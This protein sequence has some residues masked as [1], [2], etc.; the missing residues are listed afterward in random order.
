MDKGRNINKL[1]ACLV[2]LLMGAS[3]CALP[4]QAY[5]VVNLDS[6]SGA[7]LHEGGTGWAVPFGAGDAVVDALL[8]VIWSEDADLG[9][10]LPGGA[11]A[12]DG[13][14]TDI[15][16]YSALTTSFGQVDEEPLDQGLQLDNT[17]GRSDTDFYNGYVYLRVF[18]TDSPV[19]GSG[20][21]SGSQ[22]GTGA[23]WGGLTQNPAFSSD[24]EQLD[25]A[26]SGDAQADPN[27]PGVNHIPMNMTIVPEPG[28][29]ALFGVGLVT[30]VARRRRRR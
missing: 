16:L 29:F 13:S 12:P 24:Y 20:Y 22:A 1:K 18:D 10:A 28:T 25:M 30:L 14:D 5:I 8:Q 27:Y 4:A 17:T 6:Q 7:Y 11:I 26:A 3:L 15:V 9:L 23:A 2:V 21:V 19:F